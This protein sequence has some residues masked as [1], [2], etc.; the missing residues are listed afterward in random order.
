MFFIILAF[1]GTEKAS[2]SL[3]E[4]KPP[5]EFLCARFPHSLRKIEDSSA[6]S[7]IIKKEDHKYRECG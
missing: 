4:L 5:G 2:L 7:L 1:K 6:F 3:K